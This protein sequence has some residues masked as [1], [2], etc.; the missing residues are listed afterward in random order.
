[1]R[2]NP[3]ILRC[4]ARPEKN[5]ILG[6]CVDLDIS[7][8]SSSIDEVRAEMSKAIQSF[9]LS[10][11]KDNFKDA[12]P[13]PVPPLVMLDYHRVAAIVHYLRAKKNFQ[14]FCEQLI[15]KTFEVSPLCA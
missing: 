2:K 14:I 1:M 10:I 5:Y 15:P 13:R 3:Y 11:D 9:F 7:V 8:R 12:F 6:V 4:Y